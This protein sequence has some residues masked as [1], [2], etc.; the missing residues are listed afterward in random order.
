MNNITFSPNEEEYKNFHLK[1]IKLLQSYE[2]ENEV[3]G[4]LPLR[5]SRILVY[6][7]IPEGEDNK[8]KSM[9]Y[10]FSPENGFSCDIKKE[11]N[12]PSISFFEMSDGN[13]LINYRVDHNE[14]VKIKKDSIELIYSIKD[15]LSKVEKIGFDKF[16][17]RYKNKDKKIKLRFIYKIYSY[18]KENF[19]MEK[20]ISELMD[21]QKSENICFINKNEFALSSIQKGFFTGENLYI[22]F[23][24][25]NSEKIIK[26]IKIGKTEDADGEMFLANERNLLFNKGYCLYAIVDVKSKSIIG[27]VKFPCP[28]LIFFYLNE[29][30]F[31]VDGDGPLFLY[32]LEDQKTYKLKEQKGGIKH[33]LIYNYSGNKLVTCDKK[34]INIY[35]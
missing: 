2:A 8:S 13:V 7:E 11:I 25:I 5:D 31:L 35:G 24:D 28:N 30:L 3:L 20:D 15:Y 34:K 9:L 19:F 33:D 17:I 26:S 1:Q 6:N 29:K 16:L 10:V 32:E 12:V 4:L 21:K 14:I 27:E 22:N 18:S 23:Y